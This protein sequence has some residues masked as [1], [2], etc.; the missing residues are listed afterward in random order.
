MLIFDQFVNAMDTPTGVILAG[1]EGKRLRKFETI[2]PLIKVGGEPLIIRALTR[3]IEHG[4]R[5]IIVVVSRGDRLVQRT[6][7]EHASHIPADCRLRY[8]EQSDKRNSMLGSVLSIGQ[9]VQ[10]PFFLSACDLIFETDPFA[11]FSAA[12][13]SSDTISVLY[14]TDAGVNLHSGGR[15]KALLAGGAVVSKIGITLEESNALEAGV[16]HFAPDA[17]AA[18]S[19]LV[20]SR[21]DIITFDAALAAYNET[22]PLLPVLYGGGS[23]FD[24]NTPS[25]LIRTEMFLKRGSGERAGGS[26]AAPRLSAPKKSYSFSYMKELAFDVHLKSGL[27]DHLEEQLLIPSESYYSPHHLIVDKNIDELYGKKVHEKLL[28]LGY[29]V[30]KILV[31]P[32]EW[33][34][35]ADIYL[36]LANEIL[37]SGLDKKSVLLSLG[38]GVVKDLVGFLAS[39]LYRG[40]GSIHIP[41][42]L[43]AQCDA[44]IALKQGVNG[45]GGKNLLGSYYPPLSVVVDPSVLLTLDERYLRDGL[46]ECLKQAFAQSKDFYDFF[47][48]YNGPLKNLPFLEEVV[49]RSIGLKI[50]TIERDF[51]EEKEGLVYQYGH[52]IGHAVEYLS[53]YELGHGESVAIGMRVSAELACILGVSDRTTADD[54]IGMMKKYGLHVRVPA[55]IPVDDIIEALRFNKKFHSGEARFVLV[56][57][58]GALWHD[59]S[60]YTVLCSDK[61]VRE[62]I[63][64]SYADHE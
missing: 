48:A 31:D 13:Q 45:E 39:T 51:N 32:G 29:H 14:S 16:Y 43:L 54:Q 33:T 15:M 2:K 24:V 61:A 56:K 12:P 53:G 35:S 36:R 11:S 18:L 19:A 52:E 50:P 23:W 25:T 64:S 21:P 55:D 7:L 5:D 27:L 49:S 63:A 60:M 34:K 28:S 1:G 20:V 22:R 6:M 26:T 9:Q 8:V 44:A 3:M 62:A 41:T 4:I 58:I 38:G 47:A 42:T 10:G 30:N 59:R 57:E 46:A 17:Y 40:V 37:T